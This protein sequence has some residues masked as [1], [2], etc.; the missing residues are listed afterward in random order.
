[1]SDERVQKIAS[2]ET[3]TSLDVRGHLPCCVGEEIAR[4]VEFGAGALAQLV[5]R[6][7]D[8][9]SWS[10]SIEL[11]PSPIWVHSNG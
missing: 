10:D 9:V 6:R 2:V 7:G 11:T 8:A 3:V 5:G 4:G 1:V